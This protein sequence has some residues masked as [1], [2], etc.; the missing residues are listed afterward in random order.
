MLA[1]SRGKV[2]G[3]PKADDNCGAGFIELRSAGNMKHQVMFDPAEQHGPFLKDWEKCVG[4]ALNSIFAGDVSPL[5]LKEG[6][7]CDE[8]CVYG[9][10][11]GSA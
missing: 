6:R 1:L 7:A 10:I 9:G 8:N 2:T 3:A 5:W 11:C 4:A